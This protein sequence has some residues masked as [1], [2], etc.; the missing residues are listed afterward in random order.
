M[1]KKRVDHQSRKIFNDNIFKSKKKISF[2]WEK[3]S[4]LEQQNT[5]ESKKSMALPDIVKKFKKSWV[6]MYNFFCL[7]IA[8]F[9]P[10]ITIKTRKHQNK[11]VHPTALHVWIEFLT[12]AMVQ[13]EAYSLHDDPSPWRNRKWASTIALQ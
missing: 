11:C 13:L 2:T 5:G 3:C 4:F 8:E 1:I 9:I 7:V 12:N 6:L 10:L